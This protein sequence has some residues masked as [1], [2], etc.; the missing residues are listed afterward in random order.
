MA[1]KEKKKENAKDKEE[2]KKK[3]KKEKKS[4]KSFSFKDMF[5]WMSGMT[6]RGTW[7]TMLVTALILSALVAALHAWL[8]LSVRDLDPVAS[9]G[10]DGEVTDSISREELD[11]VIEGI[12]A[13]AKRYEFLKTNSPDVRNPIQHTTASVGE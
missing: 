3:S 6:A 11:E 5:S 4:L 2:A 13:R 8:F 12:D 10:G 9:D 7:N 1:K